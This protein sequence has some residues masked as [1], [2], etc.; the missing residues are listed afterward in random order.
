M[1]P[2]IAVITG[3]FSCFCRLLVSLHM[4]VIS[5][6]KIAHNAIELLSLDEDLFEAIFYSSQLNDKIAEQVGLKDNTILL[7]ER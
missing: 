6:N 5:R 4:E 7:Q 3:V 1:F 2:P